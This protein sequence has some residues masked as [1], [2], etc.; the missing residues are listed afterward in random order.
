[1][2]VSRLLVI[3]AAA[4]LAMPAAA[5]ESFSVEAIF[6]S[7]RFTPDLVSIEWMSDGN[8]YTKIERDADGRT[9]LYRV[10]ATTGDQ[11]LLVRGEDLLPPGME[12][13]IEIESYQFSHDGSRLLIFTNS[14]RVWRQNTAGIYYVWEFAKRE[15]M[16]VSQLSGYQ[17]FAKFSPDDRY[18]G[19]VREHNIFVTDLLDGKEKQLTLDGDENII[20]GTADWV[21]EEE[22][23]LRDAFRFSPDG[24][25]VAFWRFNQSAIQPFYLI[26]ETELY[27][28]LKAIRYP[29]AGVQ[30]S[31][32][33]IGVVSIDG[34]EPI[35][36]DLGAE[37]DIYIAA[38][39]FANSPGEIWF[40]RLNR[41]QNRLELLLADVQTGASRL[42][43]ADTDTAWVDVHS[44]IWI[45]DG[46]RFVYFSERDG[47]AHI[48]L[49]RR[50]G[51][52]ERKLTD[53]D[54]DVLQ[55]YG[56]DQQ[57]N[58]VYFSSA[59]DGP[60]G[61]P[62]Y[63]VGL[64]GRGLHRI[65]SATGTH[66][67][68]FNPTFTLYVDTYSRAG[69]PPVQS[70]YR[71]DGEI[72]RTLSDNAEVRQRV[73]AL[74]LNMPEFI[75]IST[76]DG[77]E[78][79]AYV[80]KPKGFDASERYPLLMYVYGGPGSQTVTDTWGGTR[81]L[82]HQTLAQEG[83]VIATVDNRGTGARGSRFKKITYMN[84][85][86]YESADQMAAAR[87]FGSLPYVDESRI[88]IWGWSYGG[89]MSSLSMLK[90]DGLFRAAISVA[91]V[92]HWRLYDTIYTERFMR[93]PEENPEG[94]RRSAP[95]TYADRLTGNLLL[96]HGTG[97]DNVH[98][99]NT[100]QLAQRLEM[101]NKQ[102][103][104]RIYPNK[105]HSITGGSTRLNLYSYFT[106]W[107]RKN[108]YEAGSVGN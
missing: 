80:I 7:D 73:E 86:E 85:G 88:G 30:N 81:Y 44:P 9:D 41:H 107:L 67:V 35:W 56:V 29:K 21:Y 97:D 83:Y 32:V 96:V 48:Y 91:P 46:Q 82:W 89:Y 72:V 4:V 31:E 59:R 57:R 11:D 25:A 69:V 84:L 66:R 45:D 92:T 43:M 103:D 71:A 15:L 68:N 78:L 14:V 64:N 34:G 26:D 8:F 37:K 39:D 90:G 17:M 108:L 23:G 65:S 24:K 99:Q 50:D 53:G 49:F 77:V 70:L 102:F 60:L 3:L 74:G 22:L 42:V 87:F 47:Y 28:E 55:V 58:R 62:L 51:S 61:R 94:Y 101:E 20:N 75:T 5:Q 54:W 10:D 13:P 106:E 33:R 63:R 95:L 100:V 6:G 105:T 12:Q 38:M 19:F 16:P 93:T 2:T 36:I 18:V 79:N 76:P 27:P 104:M 1:M 52:L 98:S 40:T